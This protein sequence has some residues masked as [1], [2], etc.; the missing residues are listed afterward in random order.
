MMSKFDQVQ[1]EVQTNPILREIKV[2][3]DTV[4]EQKQYSDREL[5]EDKIIDLLAQISREREQDNSRSE[6][7]TQMDPEK[8]DWEFYFKV[9]WVELEERRDIK[10]LNDREQQDYKTKLKSVVCKETNK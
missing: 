7:S 4:I 8:I 6:Y 9:L 10:Y 3:L 1:Q 2:Q 5:T